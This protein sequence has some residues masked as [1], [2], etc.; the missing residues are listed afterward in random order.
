MELG[1]AP[2][3]ELIA[4]GP[5]RGGGDPLPWAPLS[6]SPPKPHLAGRVLWT[7]D[8]GWSPR[9]WLIFRFHWRTMVDTERAP[10]SASEEVV[11]ADTSAPESSMGGFGTTR[12]ATLSDMG[13]ARRLSAET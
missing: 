6:R 12:P 11:L 2:R 5:P 3:W 8:A 4:T 13:L 7:A 9:K 10:D 1:G